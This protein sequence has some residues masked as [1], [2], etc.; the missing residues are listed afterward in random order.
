MNR[1]L[2]L[3][4][5]CLGVV[6]GVTA[7]SWSVATANFRLVKLDR[8]PRLN[9]IFAAIEGDEARAMAVRYLASESNRAM[10]SFYGP[11]QLVAAL[12]GVLLLK[13]QGR[14]RPVRRLLS[15]VRALLPWVLVLGALVTMAL[16]PPIVEQGRAIDFLSRASGDPPEVQRF[17][18]VHVAYILVDMLKLGSALMLAVFAWLAPS[19]SQDEERS[20]GTGLGFF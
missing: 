11:V 7:M 19:V 13:G 14:P 16:V 10:F 17:K 6:I 2:R 18:V 8:H 3:G 4:L 15:R 1:R 20:P 12:L 5:L 9:E